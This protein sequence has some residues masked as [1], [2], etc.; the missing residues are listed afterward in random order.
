MLYSLEVFIV[1]QSIVTMTDNTHYGH[2]S[3][4]EF[5]QIIICDLS[6]TCEVKPFL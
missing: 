1:R 2:T 4:M 6:I 3:G 5:L